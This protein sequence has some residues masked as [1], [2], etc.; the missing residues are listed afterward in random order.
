MESTKQTV[1]I[2]DSYSAFDNNENVCMTFLLYN[3]WYCIREINKLEWGEPIFKEKRMDDTSYY[4]I[5]SSLEEAK[6]F[7]HKL[8]QLE[9]K[10]I[11]NN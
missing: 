3:N 7:I 2:I 1:Y 9:G 8:K 6:E 4:Y 5:Y 11:I 10:K